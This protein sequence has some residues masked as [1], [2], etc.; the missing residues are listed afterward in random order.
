MEGYP[1]GIKLY[2]TVNGFS[3]AIKDIFLNPRPCLVYIDEV[4][5]FKDHYGSF[6]GFPEHLKLLTRK[7]RHKGIVV[8]MSSQRPVDV[9]PQLRNNVQEYICFRLNSKEDAE[10]VAVRV[11]NMKI[12]GVPLWQ[13]IISLPKY[14]FYKIKNDNV[15]M[16]KA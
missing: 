4:G 5:D 11:A 3:E 6:Q 15:Q 16:F 10:K 7:G 13:K 12:E 2:T 14:H 8:W 1:R 9:H